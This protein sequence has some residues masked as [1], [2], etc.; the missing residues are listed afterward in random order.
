PTAIENRDVPGPADPVEIALGKARSLA[1]ALQRADASA[2]RSVADR[3]RRP[4]HACARRERTQLGRTDGSAHAEIVERVERGGT[5]IREREEAVDQ[6][7]VR[8]LDPD[9]RDQLLGRKSEQAF[10][11]RRELVFV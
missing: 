5:E 9:T 6:S 1:T 7:G 11:H 2:L 4:A 8:P 10:P 3:D